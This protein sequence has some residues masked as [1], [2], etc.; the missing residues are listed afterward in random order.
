M[1]NIRR[2]RHGSLQFW[3][4]NRAKRIYPKVRT[5]PNVDQLK[6]LG[7]MGYKA[8]MTHIM[9]IDQDKNSITKNQP[10]FCPVTVIEC[11]PLKVLSVKFYQKSHDGLKLISEV[12][13]DNLDKELE[14][15][16]SLKK[17]K[18]AKEPN[19]DEVNEVRILAYTQPKVTGIGKKKPELLEVGIGGKSIKEK[20]DYAKSLLNKEIKIS[21]IF[22]EGQEIDV[23]A[24]TKG[25][26]FQGTVKRYGVKIRQHKS[27]KTK[28]G[29]GSLGP[30]IPKRVPFQAPQP[31]KM[32]YHTRTE[33][34][35]LFLKMGSNPKEINPKGGFIQYGLIKNDYILLKGSVPGPAKRPIKLTEPIRSKETVA[36]PPQIS[37]ISLESK[38]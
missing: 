33:Y 22:K 12:L 17:N 23:H 1:P 14:R 28:R 36:Q 5:W 21:E 13:S 19:I 4:R 9:L 25:K 37:Y 38:R 27:E 24:V 34:N 10:I 11:P 18:K 35:K 16:I 20:V 8:G 32:G 30:W 15:K 31:G 6:L 29:I 2:P 7:F 3:P 26:G